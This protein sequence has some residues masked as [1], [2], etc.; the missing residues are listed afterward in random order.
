[1]VRLVCESCLGAADEEVSPDISSV[2]E[3]SSFMVDMGA[4]IADHLCDQ[5]ESNGDIQCACACHPH[6][7]RLPTKSAYWAGKNKDLT[8]AEMEALHRETHPHQYLGRDGKP[9]VG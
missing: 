6:K 7:M 9:L 4:D 8:P 2:R 5:L 1:M 3:M